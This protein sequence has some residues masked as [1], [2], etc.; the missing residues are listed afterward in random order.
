MKPNFQEYNQQQNCPSSIEELIPK[1]HPV[2]SVNDVIEQLDLKL[3]TEVYIREDSPSYHLKIMFKVI[4]YAYMDK[5]YSSR[6]I[7]KTIR[8]NIN[9]MWLSGNQIVGQNTFARF[10][11]N[12]LKDIFKQVVMH[13][14]EESPVTLKEVFNDETKIVPLWPAAILC[15]E[16]VDKENMKESWRRCGIMLRSFAEDENPNPPDF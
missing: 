13:L 6:K 14:A 15:M 9:F 7:E 2:R 3:L 4:V 12:K 1:Y 16:K 8:K 5:I 10:R 11:S